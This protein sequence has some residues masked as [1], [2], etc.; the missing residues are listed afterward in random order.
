[1]LN[2]KGLKSFHPKFTLWNE[3]SKSIYK[4]AVAVGHRKGFIL[5]VNL[6]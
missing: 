1:M 5:R 4:N 3:E 2:E 6:S